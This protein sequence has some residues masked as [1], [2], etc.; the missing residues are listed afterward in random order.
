VIVGVV[1]VVAPCIPPITAPVTHPVSPHFMAPVAMFVTLFFSP[2][3]PLEIAPVIAPNGLEVVGVGG[4]VVTGVGAIG[5]AGVFVPE[6]IQE[7]SI[8]LFATGVL[9]QSFGSISVVLRRAIG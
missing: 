4:G 5:S 9:N 6:P 8:A 7:E 1:G 3:R 2:E